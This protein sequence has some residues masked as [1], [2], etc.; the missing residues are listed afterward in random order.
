MF[1]SSII[2]IMFYPVYFLKKIILPRW[3]DLVY[4]LEW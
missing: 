3:E 4:M 1:K 2:I